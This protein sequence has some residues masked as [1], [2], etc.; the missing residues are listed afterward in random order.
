MFRHCHS[1][2]FL[3]IFVC[4]KEFNN[5]YSISQAISTRIGSGAQKPLN[6]ASIMEPA[7]R[8]TVPDCLKRMKRG[9]N[10]ELRMWCSGCFSEA[11]QAVVEKPQ[12]AR[13]SRQTSAGLLSEKRRCLAFS[14]LSHVR[15][16][17]EC[18]RSAGARPPVVKPH[19]S[20]L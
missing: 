19:S 16:S 1:K 18:L 13:L 6:S 15:A 11:A 20:Y 14:H 17:R 5:G 7:R 3:A 4:N 9:S 10:L 2:R 12:T 8:A